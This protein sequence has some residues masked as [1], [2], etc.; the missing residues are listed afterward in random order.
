MT[1]RS[2][3]DE[4]H[5]PPFAANYEGN[6]QQL[7]DGDFVGWGQQP[8]FTQ[9]DKNGHTVFDA[10]M[11]SFTASYRAYRF[12]WSATP[13]TA[14]AVIASTSKGKSYVFMSW[15]GATNVAGWRVYAGSSPTAL[16][17]VMSVSKNA[18]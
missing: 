2:I 3:T 5:S 8:Y 6:L 18:L 16:H 11:N 13:W 14:P 12:Q 15:N 17:Y 4:K 10:H 9:F 7:S 1:A